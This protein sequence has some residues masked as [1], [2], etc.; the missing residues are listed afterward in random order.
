MVISH[1]Y[2]QISLSFLFVSSLFW[3]A[4]AFS[5]YLTTPL[6]ESSVISDKST[7]NPTSESM[8]AHMSSSIEQMIRNT[9]AEL[10]GVHFNILNKHGQ[11]VLLKHRARWS[12]LSCAHLDDRCVS[13]CASLG[14]GGW[15]VLISSWRLACFL[16]PIYPSPLPSSTFVVGLS[17]LIFEEFSMDQRPVSHLESPLQIPP[18]PQPCESVHMN[19]NPRR[20]V[21]GLPSSHLCAGF[22]LDQNL[23][24]SNTIV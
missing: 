21:S 14:L 9:S 5:F 19:S 11:I 10:W 1:S 8:W 13:I 18:R 23:T 20:C 17:V 6:L 3:K 24:V 15:D 7:L 12:P 4:A 16:G 2:V 22:R